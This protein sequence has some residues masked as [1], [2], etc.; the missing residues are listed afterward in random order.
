M[1]T[2]TPAERTGIAGT[3]GSL[4]KGKRADIIVLNGRLD[5]KR[6]FVNGVEVNR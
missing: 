4:E 3:T 1:A 2:L 6:T 5:V